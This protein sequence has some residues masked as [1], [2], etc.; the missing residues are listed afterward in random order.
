MAPKSTL[1]AIL[2]VVEEGKLKAIVDRVLPLDQVVEAH[3][4]L[5]GRGVF[6]KVVLQIG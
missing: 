4:A 3:R 6:G 2:R 1:L 5:E